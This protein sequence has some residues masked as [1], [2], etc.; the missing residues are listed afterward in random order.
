MKIFMWS[1]ICLLSI[2]QL[3]AQEQE[4]ITLTCELESCTTPPALYTF[5][6]VQFV[7]VQI[8]NAVGERGYAFEVP[9]TDMPKFYY[10]GDGKNLQY[11]LLGTEPDVKLRG[12]CQNMKNLTI[13]NSPINA[14]YNNVKSQIL[15]HKRA[16]NQLMRKART[17]KLSEEELQ[18]INE[19]VQALDA[20]KLAFLD[21]LRQHEPFFGKYAALDTY[22]AYDL[23]EEK[24]KYLN[25]VDYFANTYYQFVDFEDPV[26]E[27]SPW[28][29]ESFRMYTN[30]LSSVGL[31][32]NAFVKYMERILRKI[33]QESGTYR[34]ALSGVITILRQKKH[35]AYPHFGQQFVDR[36]RDKLPQATFELHSH[37]QSMKD[38]QIG[39][40]APDFT[41]KTPEG[42]E[43]S[44]SDLRGKVVL[45]DFW[46][47]WCGPCRRENPNVVK[48]YEK[49]KDKGFEILGIS[50][51]RSRERWLKAIEQDGLTWKHVSDLKYW[52]NAVAKQYNVR[53]IPH[54]ILLDEEGKIIARN[55][56]GKRLE[57]ALA[58]I[59]E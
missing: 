56:R 20:A 49:Y 46:A 24:D 43:L 30:T 39:G 57:Q 22:L 11:V 18:A 28:I 53:S 3:S 51:D 45:L 42:E 27:D 25:E 54:T 5:N 37:L 35:S 6:G 13:V 15:E 47:S 23:A 59:F 2:A 14:T 12:S 40:T 7:K 48:V 58:E 8:G 50:L 36:Y 41:Q 4:T 44:L 52:S 26:Y 32:H 10:V 21:S 16:T 19:E 34:M 17:T 33:P 55:L 9:K 1:L 31:S 38:L 29:Y